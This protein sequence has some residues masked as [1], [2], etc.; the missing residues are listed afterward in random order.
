[1]I[2]DLL[3][4]KKLI[5]GTVI[6]ALLLFIL[7]ASIQ[8]LSAFLGA[9]LL[10]FIFRP[11]DKNLR[12]YMSPKLSAAIILII[13][14]ILV[15]LPVIFIINGL[16]EQISLLPEQIVKIRLVKDKLAEFLPFN[17]DIDE[18]QLANQTISFLTGSI[19]PLFSNILNAI[20]ILFLLFFLLYYLILYYDDLKKL[21]IKYLPFT[22]KNNLV[23]VSRF[24]EITYSI[25]IGTFLIAIIQGALIAFNFY[26]LGIPNALFWGSVTMILAFLPI[27]G[28]PVI[29]GPAA[30]I[31]LISGQV[32]KGIALIIVGIFIS[33]LDNILR[34]I[35]NQRYGRIHPIVSILG[36]YI[37]VAQFGIVGIFIG[38][39]L[40][41]YFLLFWKLYMEEYFE[42]SFMEKIKKNI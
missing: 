33:T 34:P 23:I 21:I 31:L 5:A 9:V 37:G 36:I 40:V 27:I 35:I 20:V 14:L 17:I 24:K 26:L 18:T 22:R 6:L 8:F 29:W 4:N 39:L 11:L 28:A 41:A 13:S 30:A 25:I 7:Y 2:S 1:M 10:A 42:P 3:K 38:P 12:K 16:F 15:I 32:D 19:R